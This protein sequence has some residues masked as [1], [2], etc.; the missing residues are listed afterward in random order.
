MPI[1]AKDSGGDFTPAPEGLWPGV[2]VDVVDLGML[3]SQFG[4][5]HQIELRMVLVAEP[6]L[7]TGKPHMAVRRFT[8]SLGE[9]SNLRPFLESWRGR[10]FTPEELA[11]FDLEKLIG[12]CG[13]F[14]II[15]TVSKKGKTYGKIQTAVPYPRGME[16]MLL[17]LDYIRQ[18]ERDRRAAIE[19]EA[20]GPADD[21]EPEIEDSDIP[22]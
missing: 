22:F 17:P 8:L 20:N 9:K 5:T 3:D 15:H 12:A 13:Q 10:K 1:I 18:C 2:C 7:P 16:K 14:Q 21:F 6:A 4:P 11:G 19:N